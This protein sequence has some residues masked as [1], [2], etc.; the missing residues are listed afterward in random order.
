MDQPISV[1]IKRTGI[2]LIIIKAYRRDK[3]IWT[4]VDLGILIRATEH[5]F[6]K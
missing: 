3:V 6:A 1:D 2:C 5:T 4:Y